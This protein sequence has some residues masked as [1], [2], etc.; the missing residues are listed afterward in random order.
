[1]QDKGFKYFGTFIIRA[2]MAAGWM[3]LF[4]NSAIA[5]YTNCIRDKNAGGQ[6]CPSGERDDI[7]VSCMQKQNAS[8]CVNTMP[9]SN[10]V[11]ISEDVCKRSS[12]EFHPGMDYAVPVGT[13]VYAAAEGEIIMANDCVG[14]ASGKNKGGGRTVTIRHL[15]TDQVKDYVSLYPDPKENPDSYYVST[16]MHLSKIVKR[17][18]KVKKGE[19]I[20]YSGS[21]GCLDGKNVIENAYGAHLHFEMRDGAGLV[22]GQILDPMCSD[23]QSLCEEKSSNP[24]YQNQGGDYDAQQCRVDCAKNPDTPYCKTNKDDD[25]NKEETA[26]KPVSK[27]PGDCVSMYDENDMLSLSAA[28]ESGKN[29]GAVNWYSKIGGCYGNSPSTVGKDKGGCSYGANQIACG[30]ATN[31]KESDGGKSGGWNFYNF[32]A[33]LKDAKPAL[34]A[35]LAQGNDLDTTVKY[36]CNDQ[37]YKEENAAFRAAW[38]SL[39]SDREFYNAQYQFVND[40]YSTDA[41]NRVKKAGLDWNKLTPELQMTFVATTIAN[42]SLLTKTLN[43]LKQEYGNNLSTSEENLIAFANRYRAQEGYKNYLTNGG[44]ATYDAAQV[45]AEKDIERTL[46]SAKIRKAVEESKNK[47]SP[48]YG[49][50]PDE[51]A[52]KLT[53]KRLCDEDEIGEIIKS[54]G[55]VVSSASA[56]KAEQI[57]SQDGSYDC[58]VSKYRSSFNEC[59]FCGVFETLYNTASSLARK[60]YAALAD[61]ITNLVILGMALWLAM[62]ILKFVSS[63]ETKDPRN[64]AKAIFNQAFVVMVVIILLKTDSNKFFALALE[65]IFNTGMDL[66]KLAIGSTSSSTCKAAEGILQISQGAGLPPSMGESIVCL[67]EGI[68]EKIL[69]VMAVGSSAMCVGF[70]IKSWYGLW[71]FPHLGYVLTGIILWI[72]ALLLLIIYPWLLIDAVLQMCVAS[73]L[74]PAAIGAYAFKT[75]R[76][77]LVSKVWNT[78]M[79]AMFNFVFLSLIIGI[80]ISALDNI[81]AQSFSR[82]LTTAGDGGVDYNIMIAGDSSIAWWSIQCLK[83]VFV[84][85]LGW[86]VLGE[87]KSF[88][89]SFAGGIKLG[90]DIGSNVGTLAMSG[91]KG[92]GLAAGGAVV[93]AA[94]KGGGIIGETLSEKYNDAKLG[95][96]QFNTRNRMKNAAE[97]GTANPDGS[98]S[99]RN[100][101]GRKF[102]LKNDGSGYSYKTIFGK[103]VTKSISTNANGQQVLSVTTTGRNGT[104]TTVSNDGYIKSTVVKD[105]TGKITQQQTEMMTAAGKYLINNDGSI[106]QIAMNNIIQNSGHDAQTVNTAI[107]DQLLK[108]RMPGIAESTL[109]NKFVSRTINSGKDANGRTVFSI[110]Q[111]NSD[112]S[113]VN[114]GMTVGGDSGRIMT[115]IE[116]ITS[117]GKATKYASDG[118]I[119]S[120]SSY[121]Y[122][123]GSIDPDSVKQSFSFTRYYNKL[124][125][126][127][128]DSLGY[129]ATGI[130]KDSILFSAEDMENFRNQ[131]ADYGTAEAL[132]EFK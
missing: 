76:K 11:R 71:I 89:N 22:K 122:K 24:W 46:T 21:S 2:A 117:S 16:Y 62:T 51:I 58:R 83:L 86:A 115:E 23:I 65:P 77:M 85:L 54:R 95:I 60:S 17:S 102:T 10:T 98:I 64:L 118:I 93:G 109:N 68:Q 30:A 72:S 91:V 108:E 25:K 97:Q 33:Y 4:M 35:K 130:P 111:I 123:G 79:N 5:D 112:G 37:K 127:P 70:K 114:V 26:S 42:P 80:L 34:Y 131:I 39:G 125:G 107:L 12:G 120:R 52:Q 104:S 69:D 74:L 19:L 126:N 27:I 36:A 96:Q 56:Q 38:Q 53:G 13:E 101:F 113:T 6:N 29:A 121:R 87:A 48:Y 7:N 132:D 100:A 106:N 8:G 81:T 94:K 82:A 57:S 47:N 110:A 75:T 73:I 61:G 20:G 66:A 99:Y 3:L 45:R 49:M 63:F 9:V 67:V 32:M 128:M 88:A 31:E 124:Y 90:G 55:P 103:T 18:G 43:A 1:M 92:A 15:K 78:F 50:T 44:K 40:V 105:K 116:Q 84:L 119:N 28:G 41:Q 129:M 59:I 14:S